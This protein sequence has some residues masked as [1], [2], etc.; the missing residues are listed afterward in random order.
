MDTK[1]SFLWSQK[2]LFIAVSTFMLCFL[3]IHF[4]V[5]HLRQALL[6]NDGVY[7]S[8]FYMHFSSP[9]V[10]SMFHTSHTFC[11][12]NPSNSTSEG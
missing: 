8:I 4:Y 3:K 6:H 1:I 10:C 5:I 12:N 2:T 7:K 9:P 11:L